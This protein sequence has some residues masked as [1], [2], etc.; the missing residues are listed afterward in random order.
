MYYSTLRREL[1][2]GDIV[3]FTGKGYLSGAIRVFCSVMTVFRW[4][5]GKATWQQIRTAWSHVGVIVVDSGRVML[6]EST[7]IRGGVKGVRLAAFSEVVESYKGKIAVRQ[8]KANIDVMI[9]DEFV[10]ETLGKPYE[11]H[12][13]EL[14]GSA[15]DGWLTGHNKQDET[16]F[17]CSE[18]VAALYQRLGLLPSEP[19]SN[20]Y[21]PE[22]F[23][24]GGKVDFTF[25][26]TPVSLG[27]EIEVEVKQK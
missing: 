13:L 2:T 24:Q 14:M 15:W 17:F 6:F 23:R 12:L 9:V 7:S 25:Q 1:K 3:G 16:Y 11:M 5:F 4:M 22:D 18:L 26:S 8:L 21:T 20:E 10:V 19:P 27:R